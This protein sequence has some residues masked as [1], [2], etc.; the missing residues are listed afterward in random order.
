MHHLFLRGLLSSTLCI[1]QQNVVTASNQEKDD[2]DVICVSVNWLAGLR[3]CET[4][5]PVYMTCVFGSVLNL[6]QT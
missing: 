2:K 4:S 3:W 6:Q 1:Q 5:E